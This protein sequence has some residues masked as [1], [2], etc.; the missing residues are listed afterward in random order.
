[1]FFVFNKEKI[2]SYFVATFAVI[3]MLFLSNVYIETE[4]TIATASGLS[5]R[6]V[7][8]YS[9]QTEAK[10]VAFTMNCAWTADDIEQILQVLNENEVK[11]TFFCVGEWVDKYPEAVKK[12]HESGHEIRKSLGYTS[13]CKQ[14]DI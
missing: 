3:V 2:Y 7:P 1:M 8:I 6:M 9:V 10:Q 5:E 13:T 11:I 12:I 4:K 14:F